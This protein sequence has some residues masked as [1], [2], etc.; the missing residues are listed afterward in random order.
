MDDSAYVRPTSVYTQMDM[1]LVGRLCASHGVQDA[2]FRRHGN[3]IVQGS[4][5]ERDFCATAAPDQHGAV[6]QA[7]ADVTE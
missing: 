7:G 2:A 1:Y 3:D 6:V 4:P 5:I